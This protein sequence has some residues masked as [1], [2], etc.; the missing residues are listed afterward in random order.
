MS[1]SLQQDIAS[2]RATLDPRTSIINV[3]VESTAT[4]LILRGMVLEATHHQ[5]ILQLAHTHGAH[6]QDE[7][8][9]LTHGPQYQRGLV[10]WSVADVRAQPG[11]QHELVSQAMYGEALELLYHE[12]AWWR[13]RLSDGYLGWISEHGLIAAAQAG[14]F[15][16]NATHVVS[17]RLQPVYGLEG[18][19]IT[20][21]PWQT[22]L[23]IDE[24]RDGMAFWVAPDGTPSM[25]NADD[26]MPLEDRPQLTRTGCRETL[27]EVQK[28]IGVPYLWGGSSS[29]GFDC[30]GL[31][32]AFYL[33]MGHQLPRDADQQVDYGHSVERADIQAGD[34]LF[35]ASRSDTERHHNITHVSIALNA[36][37]MIHANQRRWAVTID[38][39]DEVHA[40]FVQ[41]NDPG[42]IAIRRY[43][44]AE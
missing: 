43:A 20:L 38:P 27:T 21:L 29:Y 28:F 22:P 7:I 14:D 36:D 26:L 44:E 33:W 9:V 13:V 12:Q 30:S 31:A 41:Q 16:G 4:A 11:R 1:Q 42:L 17:T 24:F 32:Q 23:P 3:S 25:T 2:F 34:L 18:T 40:R 10:T 8:L 15:R 35:W 39:I 19:Q 6:I 37:E 5:Q